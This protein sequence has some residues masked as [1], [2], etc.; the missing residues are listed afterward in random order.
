MFLLQ[1]KKKQNKH[2]LIWV[3]ECLITMSTAHGKL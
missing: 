1:Q 3:L 2:F